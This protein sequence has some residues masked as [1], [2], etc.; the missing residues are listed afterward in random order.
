MASRRVQGG[1]VRTSHDAPDINKIESCVN[2]FALRK[3]AGRDTNN[4]IQGYQGFR[5]RESEEYASVMG[6]GT[7][8]VPSSVRRVVAAK[9]S[10]MHHI[11]NELD[12]KN[13]VCDGLVKPTDLVKKLK[14][15]DARVRGHNAHR[16]P[17]L[18]K[19]VAN[20]DTDQDGKISLKEWETFL[21]DPVTPCNMLC[22]EVPPGTYSCC[23]AQ[24]LKFDPYSYGNRDKGGSNGAK[25]QNGSRVPG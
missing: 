23:A 15:M 5:R 17:E 10:E 2:N 8:P 24:S 11:F 22:T 3:F 13:G 7:Y 1:T 20:M 18:E 25:I 16:A 4:H 12:S 9:K 21:A 6:K 14:Q 19:L